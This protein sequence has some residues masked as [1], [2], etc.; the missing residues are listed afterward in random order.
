VR[1]PIIAVGSSTGGVSALQEL[2]GA[3]PADFPGALLIV[4]HL[5]PIRLS[6]LRD[7]LD[8]AG[9]M[10]A[11]IACDGDIVRAGYIYVAIPD[12]HL[13]LEG[14]GLRVTRG[15]RDALYRPSIDV[16]FRS[17]S[18]ALGTH[19]IGVVLTGAL[20]DGTSGLWMI[21][22]CGGTTIVQSP[23]EAWQ[24]S[25]PDSAIQH[26]E[27]DHVVCIRAMPLLFSAL[28]ARNERRG[29]RT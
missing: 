11:R 10:S 8:G 29:G 7:I 20:S 25:M 28:I 18:I 23:T 9:P 24:R 21:K 17:C 5:S 1:P 2:A 4:N 19:A 15:P 3:M 13:M 14:A 6:H 12:H 22:D 16:L 26:V 27:I